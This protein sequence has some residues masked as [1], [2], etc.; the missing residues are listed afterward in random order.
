MRAM[1]LLALVLGACTPDKTGPEDTGGPA[2]TGET[3]DTSDTDPPDEPAEASADLC[4]RVQAGPASY[5]DPRISLSAAHATVRL[6][7]A[8]EDFVSVDSALV[9]AIEAGGLEVPDMAGYAAA[10]DLCLLPGEDGLGEAR[11]STFGDLAWIDPGTGEVALPEGVTGVV[12]DLRGLPADPELGAALAGAAGLALATDV[13]GLDEQIRR[14]NGFVDQLF[15]RSNVYK[16]TVTERSRDDITALGAVDLPLVLVTDSRLAPEA[17]ALAATLASAGRAWIVGE[18]VMTEVA[19]L[20]W[21][22]MDAEGLMIPTRRLQGDDGC[23]ADT[24]PALLRTDAPED[25]LQGVDLS[26]WSPPEPLTGECTRAALPA[27]AP[28]GEDLPAEYSS[29]ATFEAGLIVA[30][31]VLRRF[32]PYFDTV[33]DEIDE[34]LLSLFEIMPLN[35]GGQ[36]VQIGTLGEALHDGHVFFGDYAGTDAEGYLPVYCDHIDGRPVVVESAISQ[37]VPGDTI[38]AIDGEPIEEV[39]ARWRTYH[40]AATEGYATDLAGRE[41]QYMD[42]T[43]TYTVEDPDGVEREEVVDPQ[44]VDLLYELSYT[45]HT[46]PNG[47]LDDLDAPEIAYLNMS[48]AVTTD[49]DEAEAIIADAATA[50]GLVVDM[51]GYPGIDHYEIASLLH[52]TDFG[53][54]IFNTH[55]WSGADSMRV[56]QEQYDLSAA[57]DPYTGPL[58]LLTSPVTVSAAE[59]FGMMLVDLPNLTIVGRNSAG[60]NGNITGMR[61]PGSFYLTFTGM[62]VLFPDGS[63]FHGV[64]LVPDVEVGPTAADYRDGTDPELEA[65]IAVIRGG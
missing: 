10:L 33:G 56:D 55:L 5:D 1:S 44:P 19:E 38:T 22:G 32:F 49:L 6:F 41:L 40:G 63:T 28:W 15:S 48:D 51:R 31:G 54:P 29:E 7:G 26:S 16:T 9:D 20:T 47:R 50:D 59:N 53:S 13:P 25:A 34:R 57:D 61:L 65:A 52:S 62:E 37:F 43:T 30:H 21:S 64:G 39:Y 14:W 60:T 35:R 12:I 4:D 3:P 2:D 45:L 17:A 18:D 24:V 8:Q 58:V 46:R 23:L 42:G 27:R 11:V 36:V